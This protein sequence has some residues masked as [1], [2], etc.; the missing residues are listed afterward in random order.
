MCLRRIASGDIASELRTRDDML[1]I[2]AIPGQELTLMCVPPGSGRRMAIDRDG[3]SVLDSDDNC[4]G[5]YNPEQTDSDGDG[6]GDGC[7]NCVNVANGPARSAG[8]PPQRDSSGRGYG[9]MCDGDLNYDGLVNYTDLGILQSLFGNSNADAD[10][11][12]DGRV[13]FTDVGIFRT[14]FLI[15]PGPSGSAP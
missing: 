11:D 10:M 1:A 2:A 12:G 7:D 3:D 9:N 15:K 6:I 13:N 5:T 8:G 4:L 14:R